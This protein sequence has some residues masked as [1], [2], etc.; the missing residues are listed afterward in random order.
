M[1]SNISIVEL[2]TLN[3]PEAWRIER[4]FMCRAKLCNVYGPNSFCRGGGDGEFDQ[5]QKCKN[6]NS[7]R[8]PSPPFLRV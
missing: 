1:N 7:M 2:T 4:T 8:L 6:L 5:K 3:L